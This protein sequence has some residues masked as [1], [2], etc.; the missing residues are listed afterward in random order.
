MKKLQLENLDQ[1]YVDGPDNYKFK[2]LFYC[3]NSIV[4]V[5]KRLCKFR[6]V[7]KERA[8]LHA[9]MHTIFSIVLWTVFQ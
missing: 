5:L 7:I 9:C 3:K 4:H 2:Q 6:M 8:C 1:Y